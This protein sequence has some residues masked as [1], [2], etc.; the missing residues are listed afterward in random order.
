[1]HV[2]ASVRILR[3]SQS[4]AI[5][6]DKNNT[7]NSIDINLFFEA[8]ILSWTFVAYLNHYYL[9]STQTTNE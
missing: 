8:G 3:K 1:M 2:N 4:L 9:L 6:F 5:L 7:P